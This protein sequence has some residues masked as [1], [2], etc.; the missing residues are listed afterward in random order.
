MIESKSED[1]VFYEVKKRKP[2]DNQKIIE[3]K[4]GKVFPIIMRNDEG[5]LQNA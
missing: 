1:S 4:C 3:R 2:K 5:K